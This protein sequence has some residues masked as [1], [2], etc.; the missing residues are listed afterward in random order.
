MP[1]I[2]S[3][4]EEWT[5]EDEYSYAILLAYTG[6]SPVRDAFFIQALQVT[7]WRTSQEKPRPSCRPFYRASQQQSRQGEHPHAGGPWETIGISPL[8]ALMMG[9]EEPQAAAAAAPHQPPWRH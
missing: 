3:K 2:N 9:Q 4:I 8:E 5:D 7:H 6:R 1:L